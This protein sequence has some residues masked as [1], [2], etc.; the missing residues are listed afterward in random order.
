MAQCF[1]F[2]NFTKICSNCNGEM[3]TFR[4]PLCD[5][6]ILTDEQKK[7]YSFK[8]KVC[9]FENS[10]SLMTLSN[11]Y[12]IQFIREKICA[13]KRKVNFQWN[14]RELEEKFKKLNLS[15]D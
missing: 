4:I 5:Y 3:K 14:K 12:A 15:K 6:N 13:E 9:N 8:C 11:R 2:F 7:F 10:L 1:D